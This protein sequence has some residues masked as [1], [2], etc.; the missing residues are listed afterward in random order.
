VSKLSVSAVALT[1]DLITGGAQAASPVI[2]P[3]GRQV[4]WTTVRAG[5]GDEVSELRLARAGAGAVPVRLGGGR[6]PRWS[7]DSAWLFYV[8]GEEVRRL[9]VTAG[10]PAGIAGRVLRWGGEVSG[11]LPLAGGRLVAVVASDEHTEEDER[12]QAGGDDAMV[13][14]E[15]AVRQ[16]WRWHRLR[17]LDL[18]SGDL[19]PLDGLTGRHVTGVAQRPGGGP[20]AVI[21]LP[22]RPPADR[23]RARQ[24][25][26]S[27]ADQLAMV[28]PA[29]SCRS[30]S[31]AG[32]GVCLVSVNRRRKKESTMTVGRA[33][34]SMMAVMPGGMPPGRRP[35]I[36]SCRKTSRSVSPRTPSSTWCW[37]RWLA[38]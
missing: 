17:L 30:I 35:A 28:T 21:S 13:W 25:G 18:A 12:R 11:L 3:D 27:G 15:R 19:A 9:R 4:A 26:I 23:S 16:H 37:S 10:Q 6:L 7:T 14:S 22:S 2:S 36:Q 38:V 5:E 31:A 20:L 24:A 8:A 32:N 33:C 34:R 29:L 1:A